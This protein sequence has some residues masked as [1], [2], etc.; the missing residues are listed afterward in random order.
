MTRRYL[1]IAAALGVATPS[2]RLTAQAAL[3]ATLGARYTSTLVHD[4]IVTALDVRPDIAPALALALALP[5]SRPWRL[6]ILLDVSTSAVRRRDANGFVAPITRLWMVGA[7][8]GLRH[9]LATWL[10]GRAAAGVL[11][12]LPAKSVGLFAE[13]GGI[14]PFA[15]VALALTPPPVTRYGLAL[16]IAGDAHRFQTPALRDAG[17]TASRL[18][19]RVT[20]GIRSRIWSAR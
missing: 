11:T 20:A 14:A 6:D 18:V 10:D 1:A 3:H 15:S 7:G 5:L 9:P 13:G 16:E 12:H 8:V 19:Y 2:S 4:S 17:F